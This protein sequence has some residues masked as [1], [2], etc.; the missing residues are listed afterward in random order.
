[1]DPNTPILVGVAAFQQKNAD[2]REALEPLA[3]MERSLRDAAADAGAPSL[4]A[5]A[6]EILVPKGIW[7]YSD[8]GRLLAA[9][10]GANSARSVLA[11]IGV[12]QQTL[13]T[14]ACQ[15]ISSGEASVVLVTGAE[16]K[17]RARCF[18]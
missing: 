1:M 6:D 10:L 4:L 14:R 9:S 15:K 3:I 2:F 18:A 5:R 12:S 7:S 13:L 11:E 17:Y 16:A 8:P